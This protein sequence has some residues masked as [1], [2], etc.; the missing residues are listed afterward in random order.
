MENNVIEFK[1]SLIGLEDLYLGDSN[2]IQ[3][4]WNG[5][6]EI[7]QITLIQPVAGTD[8]LKSLDITKF[9]YALV[10][11]TDGSSDAYLY[12]YN[13]N[14]TS[15]EEIPA[16]VAPNNA[17]GRWH[18]IQY[19]LA[20]ITE[21]I[22]A[23]VEALTS[24]D[25]QGSVTEAVSAAIDSI[26]ESKIAPSVN[27][28]TSAIQSAVDY[29]LKQS[30]QAKADTTYNKNQYAKVLFEDSNGR[31]Y[32]KEYISSADNSATPVKTATASTN[33]LYSESGLVLN[34]GYNMLFRSNTSRIEF[35]TSDSGFMQNGCFG[36]NIKVARYKFKI[37]G[38]LSSSLE[39][40]LI[41][42]FEV[43]CRSP[44]T[45][46]S[47]IDGLVTGSK[48]YLADFSFENVWYHPAWFLTSFTA[49]TDT[50][51]YMGLTG[52]LTAFTSGDGKTAVPD[53]Q[54]FC[55]VATQAIAT[56]KQWI[57]KIVIESDDVELKS[58][59]FN[60]SMTRDTSLKWQWFAI[61]P[62]GGT[63]IHDLGCIFPSLITDTTGRYALRYFFLNGFIPMYKQI[64]NTG[65]TILRS[66]GSNYFAESNIR[67]MEGAVL[68]DPVS[69]PYTA[70]LFNMFSVP[71]ATKT[72]LRSNVVR[73][74]S[75]YTSAQAPNITGYS[76]AAR[77]NSAPNYVNAIG[78]GGQAQNVSYEMSAAFSGALGS[79]LYVPNKMQFPSGY[80]F[81]QMASAKN[82]GNYAYPR[83]I[84]DA[85]RSSSVYNN[86][87]DTI[88]PNTIDTIFLLRAY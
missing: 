88:M 50:Y 28:A 87:A 34:A 78:G 29:N 42:S 72:Y 75:S 58:S 60:V 25:L 22:R 71:D 8:D 17:S 56:F 14:S 69:P 81:Y 18:L 53:N 26:M 33:G 82:D 65:N 6:K 40:E 54:K 9:K 84:L 27:A 77:D 24:S 74:V 45:F 46:S 15:D 43:V 61:R 30:G 10:T 38:K 5:L 16:V 37:Y 4:R 23:K 63:D 79:R 3:E 64:D 7:T 2:G 1:T 44:F 19:G 80:S 36:M 67:D 49:M 39:A 55:F 31:K 85:S 68:G 57:T 21:E 51:S 59:D 70:E 47:A 62:N 41:S 35:N 52:F 12:W 86:S 20:N 32:Y 13:Q 66:V 73:K 76:G 11:G 83:L 48:F